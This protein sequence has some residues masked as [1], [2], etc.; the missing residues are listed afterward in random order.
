MRR[1]MMLVF[2]L[3]GCAPDPVAVTPPDALG[4]ASGEQAVGAGGS[5]GAAAVASGGATGDTWRTMA[6]GG[7]AGSQASAGGTDGAPPVGADGPAGASAGAPGMAGATGSS[8]VV[9]AAGA[10]G[11]SGA[12]AGGAY[13]AAGGVSMGVAGSAGAAGAPAPKTLPLGSSCW[14]GG[15][16][17]VAGTATCWGDGAPATCHAAIRPSPDTCIGTACGAVDG[18]GYQALNC[19]NGT[20]QVLCSGRMDCLNAGL[21]GG[22]ALL[23]PTADVSVCAP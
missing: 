4:G 2:L 18:C 12:G 9:G 7:A 17:C 20:M 15:L 6:A 23:S 10:S 8:G 16:P 3:I 11:G 1:F 13:G 14:Q 21:G 19:V 22:C 5:A